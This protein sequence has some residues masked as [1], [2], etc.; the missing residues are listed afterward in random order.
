MM[1]IE[2]HPQLNLMTVLSLF[3]F[4]TCIK[5]LKNLLYIRKIKKKM[6]V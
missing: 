1:Y 2:P 3:N 4:D 5:K 6:Y